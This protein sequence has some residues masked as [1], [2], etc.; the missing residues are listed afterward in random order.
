MFSFIKQYILLPRYN[1]DASSTFRN[2]VY[3]G[4]NDSK[5]TH[6]FSV[7]NKLALLMH[8]TFEDE[9]QAA[10]YRNA[11]HGFIN[12]TRLTLSIGLT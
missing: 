7:N 5:S 3:F 1:V 2:S 6:Y 11:L 8:R 9:T 10:D 12:T 4:W